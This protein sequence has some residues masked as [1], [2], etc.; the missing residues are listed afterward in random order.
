[1]SKGTVLVLAVVFCVG[2]GVVKVSRRGLQGGSD[3][4]QSDAAFRD[5]SFQAKIDI[6]NSRKPHL[7]TGR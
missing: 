7:S 4:R 2:A 6:E 3:A 1:M 5:G